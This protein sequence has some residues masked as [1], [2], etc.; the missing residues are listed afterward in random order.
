MTRYRVAVGKHWL[1][2][3][4]DD[5]SDGIR[6]TDLPEDA[7]SWVTHEKALGAY[8]L[9]CALFVDGVELQVVEEPDFPASWRAKKQETLSVEVL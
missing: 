9:A 2:A 6:L 8:A 7:C 5:S 1:A 3:V 4:Y